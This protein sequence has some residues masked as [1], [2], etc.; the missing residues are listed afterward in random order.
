MEA[1]S[2][3]S[4]HPPIR[5]RQRQNVEAHWRSRVVYW[6]IRRGIP[7]LASGCRFENV[8]QGCQQDGFGRHFQIGHDGHG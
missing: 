3:Q 4:F 7:L 8:P 1:Q 6:G 5:K 2:K